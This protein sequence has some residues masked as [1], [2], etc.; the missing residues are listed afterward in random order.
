MGDGAGVAVG[1]GVGVRSGVGVD[2]CGTD[3]GDGVDVGVSVGTEV[4]AG[5]SVGLILAFVGVGSSFFVG[6]GEVCTP[7]TFVSE[8]DLLI[9]GLE[10][11]FGFGDGN[12]TISSFEEP[13]AKEE[14]KNIELITTPIK[15]II[16][17]PVKSFCLIFCIKI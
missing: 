17:L 7:A 13:G 12:V 9:S 8:T 11:S 4:D 5:T 14:I 1:D 6:D 16:K 3:V 2:S 15:I 10:S